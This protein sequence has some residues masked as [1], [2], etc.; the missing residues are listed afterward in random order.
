MTKRKPPLGDIVSITLRD[1]GSSIAI[2]M[3]ASSEKNMASKSLHAG[4]LKAVHQQAHSLPLRCQDL[5][6]GQLGED[7]HKR[8]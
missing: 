6:Q 4:H 2:P 7:R 5:P 8:G 1:M 3:G